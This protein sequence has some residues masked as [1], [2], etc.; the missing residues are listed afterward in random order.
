[1]TSP[2]STDPPGRAVTSPTFR[3][4]V[5]FALYRTLRGLVSIVPDRLALAMGDWLGWTA[6][7]LLR[8]RRDVVEENLARAFPEE[9]PSWRRR[10][11]RACY[12]HVG[13]EGVATFMLA[14][15]S[16]GRI[17]EMTEIE[18]LG[19][20]E[21]AL[22]DGTG[23]IMTT[24][25][26]GN[27]EMAGAALAC[28]G[29]PIDAVVRIQNNPLF[30]GDLRETRGRLGLTL[31]P[32]DGAPKSI[33]RSLRNGRLVALVADQNAR[34]GLFVDFFGTPAATARGP[35]VLA[36]RS[37]ASLWCGVM[38]RVQVFPPRYRARFKR[39][40][41]SAEGSAGDDDVGPILQEIASAFE[42]W[43]RE[44]PEQYFWQHKRWLTRPPEEQRGTG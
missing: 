44:A 10:V 19:E 9:S 4:R 33:L 2:T 12:R 32:R 34:A 5:E 36:R 8:V 30:D 40:D 7:V 31:I 23:L 39:I 14:N 21:A 42:G 43:I 22:A 41:T 20:L 24:G 11:A 16:P 6:G 3:H 29:L 26:F 18:N 17:R 13:R 35:A 27:W 28:R 37:G 38:T 25:H 15:A 1:M